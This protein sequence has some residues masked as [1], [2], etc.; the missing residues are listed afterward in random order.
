MDTGL[1]SLSVPRLRR[2]G[3]RA[4]SDLIQGGRTE[5]RLLART[6]GRQRQSSVGADRRGSF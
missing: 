4:D 6:C 5:R 2:D 1:R 3:I